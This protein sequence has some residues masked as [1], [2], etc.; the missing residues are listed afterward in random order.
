MWFTSERNYMRSFDSVFLRSATED[1]AQ[2]DRLIESVWE[3]P[4]QCQIC[5][6]PENFS[7]GMWE[8]GVY[9]NNGYLIQFG[10][11]IAGA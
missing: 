8:F 5:Y 7:Y 10:Q 6:P 2:D 1:S 4:I 11:G 9:D 3:M